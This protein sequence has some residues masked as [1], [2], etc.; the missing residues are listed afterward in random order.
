MTSLTDQA[1]AFVR[2]AAQRDEVTLEE[3]GDRRL[4]IVSNTNP[5]SDTIDFTEGGDT[6]LATESN[7]DV[8]RDDQE[9]TNIDA[10]DSGL[11]RGTLA[12]GITNFDHEDRS[13]SVDDTDDTI[14]TT[15][16]EPADDVR[17]STDPEAIRDAVEDAVETGRNLGPDWLD[18]ATGVAVVLLVVGAILWLARPLL[19]IGAEVVAE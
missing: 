16:T 12:A 15:T 11:S 19:T 14:R 2:D 6:R 3:G 4:A 9:E 7:V 5:A 17:D 1:E 10:N 8:D 13:D 18:E